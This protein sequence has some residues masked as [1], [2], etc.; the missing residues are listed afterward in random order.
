MSESHS[1]LFVRRFRFDLPR[2]RE[3]KVYDLARVQCK[4]QKRSGLG[5]GDH[6]QQVFAEI[7]FRDS[8]GL[9]RA[10]SQVEALSVRTTR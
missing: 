1:H 2:E 9:D 8:L 10:R 5:G 3:R 4:S 7:S 6:A